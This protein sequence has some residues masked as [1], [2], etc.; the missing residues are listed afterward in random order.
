MTRR[1]SCNG[2]R[3]SRTDSEPAVRRSESAQRGCDANAPGIRH[4]IGCMSALGR[5]LFRRAHSALSRR[6]HKANAS[7]RGGPP[8]KAAALRRSWDTLCSSGRAFA[9]TLRRVAWPRQTLRRV[10]VAKVTPRAGAALESGGLL[11]FVGGAPP[12]RT[13]SSRPHSIF[14]AFARS[15]PVPGSFLL[16]NPSSCPKTFAGGPAR[17]WV[18]RCRTG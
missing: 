4:P 11:R 10:G 3:R 12:R 7:R 14:A 15:P 8:T 9:E 18:R 6:G 13:A 17:L 1:P 2:S 16:K 5:D